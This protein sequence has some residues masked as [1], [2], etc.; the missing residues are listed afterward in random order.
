MADRDPSSRDGRFSREHHRV[1]R[2][3]E[4]SP[5]DT[6]L[7]HSTPCM[8]LVPN[9]DALNGRM[10]GVSPNR[11]N[12]KRDGYNAEYRRYDHAYDASDSHT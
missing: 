3:V 6:D 1:G 9:T 8:T 5:V 10:L 11:M 2:A 7:H 4:Q 12:I